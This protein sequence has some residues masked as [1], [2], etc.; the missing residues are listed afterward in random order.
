MR[1]HLVVAWMLLLQQAPVPK[2]SI[3]GTVVRNGTG[4]PIAD[5]RVTLAQQGANR[6]QSASPFVTT[7]D[8]GKF[9]FTGLDASS[10]RLTIGANGYVQLAYGQRV[11][12]DQ[13]TPITLAAGQSVKDISVSMTP[14]GNVS[15]A[16]RDELGR[17]AV[18]VQVQ[19]LRAS[20]NVMGQ[21]TLNN[22][23]SATTN[24][25]GEYRIF[26]VTPGR[27]Y[28][29]AG[30]FSGPA[31]LA[32]MLGADGGG[33]SNVILNNYAS[34]F[35]PGVVDI[36][37]A[38]VI[39]IQP[40]AEMSAVNVSV[41]R[42]QLHKIRGRVIDLKTGRPPS[43]AT[44]SMESRS[45]S[46]GRSNF[47]SVSQS[48]NATDGTFEIR[49]VAPGTYVVSTSIQDASPA[50]VRTAVGG[51]AAAV[52]VADSDVD[53]ITLNLGGTNS[54]TG[55][56]TIEGRELTAMPN[57][58]RIQVRLAPV[59]LLAGQS[60][61]YSQ[62]LHSDGT[63]S[64]NDVKPGQY[65]VMTCIALESNP[66]GCARSTPEFYLKSA[67]FDSSDVM[68]TPL[69][70]TGAVTTP[71]EIVLGSKPGQVEGVVVND[72]QQPA[73]GIDVVLVPD[74]HRDRI[75][76]YKV[77]TSGPSG[78]FTILGVPPGVYKVFAWEAL[79]DFA[80]FDPD[81]VKRS[82]PL[83]KPVRVSESD[84]QTIDLKIIPSGK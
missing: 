75:D 37:D 52:T 4:E 64:M 55:H 80:Y 70:F 81:L 79:E 74:Q 20:Y 34:K 48:Y 39:E 8:R 5:A 21:R 66:A 65:Q 32:R 24:D 10:Y 59:D 31:S 56:L 41:S 22:M 2:G 43:A 46:G 1:F 28:V 78:N 72:R 76:L 15:G 71:L 42:Q 53:G 6:Q 69:P 38:S 83:A 49:D 33:A 14:A 26:W 67:R 17:A 19:L 11:P 9:I 60:S 62:P 50:G 57:F 13:G 44:I 7:D 84:R 47:G 82:E 58:E 23:G 16:I 3:E 63:F 35:Y 68:N 29:S 51:A 77:V 73:A 54:I 45:L 12:G 40:G 30:S 36:A 61:P 18:G 27:Y 25:R